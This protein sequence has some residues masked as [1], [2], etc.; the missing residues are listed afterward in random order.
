MD[1]YTQVLLTII[2]LSLAVIAFKMPWDMSFLSVDA[3]A[4]VTNAN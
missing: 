4:T 3:T 1:R 2:A